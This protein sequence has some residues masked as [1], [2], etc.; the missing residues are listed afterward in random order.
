MTAIPKTFVPLMHIFINEHIE[1]GPHTETN[2]EGLLF[3]IL[4]KKTFLIQRADL[5]ARSFLRINV[6][7]ET[8]VLLG[9]RSLTI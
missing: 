3:I 2:Q 6:F 8:I 1:T 4:K 9:T 7:F 5:S